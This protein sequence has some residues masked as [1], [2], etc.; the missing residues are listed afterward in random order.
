MMHPILNHPGVVPTQ[1][2]GQSHQN[3]SRNL[4]HDIE[5]VSRVLRS[6]HNDVL[7]QDPYV[8]HHSNLVVPNTQ[9][10]QII[11]YNQLYQS[12]TALT[13]RGKNYQ[14]HH[15]SRQT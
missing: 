12:V 11:H 15:L 7:S 14:Q 8:K 10:N 2:S 9:Q 1:N 3:K 5:T 4:T 6:D 13:Q